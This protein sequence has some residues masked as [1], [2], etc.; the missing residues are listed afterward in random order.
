MASTTLDDIIT[1]L[2]LTYDSSVGVLEGDHI[3]SVPKISV[4]LNL[5]KLLSKLDRQL[6]EVEQV[7]KSVLKKIKK[8]A[9]DGE[10]DED[11]G[12]GDKKRF[13]SLDQ[14]EEERPELEQRK[15]KIDGVDN[16]EDANS[17]EED[18]AAEVEEEE[19]DDDEGPE[20]DAV[21][22]TIGGADKA[23]GGAGYDKDADDDVPL[24]NKRKP[25]VT[26]DEDDVGLAKRRKLVKSEADGE[27]YGKE[28]D[29]KF[30][31]ANAHGEAHEDDND[32]QEDD[33]DDN[34]DEHEDGINT[35]KN[36]PPE[37]RGHYT[38]END[39]RLKNP[40]SEF[41]TSQ[42]LPAEAIAKLGLF[43]ESNNGLETHGK[44]YLKKKYG[45]ASYPENDLYDLLPGPIPNTDFSKNKPPSNQVQFTTF[46]SYIESFFRPFVP[47]DIDFLKEKY[48]IPAIGGFDEKLNNYDPATT[49]FLIPKLGP[50]YADLWTAADLSLANKISSPSPYQQGPDSYLPKG[51]ID[52]LSDDKLYTEDISCGPLSSRLL[53]AILCN[54]ESGELAGDDIK[55]EDNFNNDDELTSS[56]VPQPTDI[57]VA[58]QLD[59]NNE[60]YKLTSEK[61]DF[62]S[63]EERL[64]R[65]LKYIG[66]FMNLPNGK[67]K[68]VN[69]S[70]D[71]NAASNSI[72]GD[73]SADGNDGTGSGTGTGDIN[74]GGGSEGPGGNGEGSGDGSHIIDNDEWI[75]NREDDEVCAELRALQRELQETYKRNRQNKK[76]LIP[77]VDDQLAFQEYCTILEDLDKQVDQAYIKRLRVKNKKKKGHAHSSSN[78]ASTPGA[79]GAGSSESAAGLQQTV[80]SGLRS[81][82]DKRSKWIN[83]IGKLFKSPELMKRAPVE[84]VLSGAIESDDEADDEDHIDTAAETIMNKGH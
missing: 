39:T 29:I 77:I 11:G 6:Q 12:E 55:T 9:G 48:V 40:K 57:D 74:N 36:L 49:P 22:R 42:T 7:D 76:K 3:Q 50:F 81:L 20:D 41:V 15:D 38:H 71:D 79:T 44:E 25:S 24:H 80:N 54:N 8:I 70:N 37:Q 17:N 84:S 61:S 31:D 26:D 4:L 13:G 46:Q 75:K 62:H 53:S 2:R 52:N 73:T 60:S 82:L 59:L 72:N 67:K 58:T 33:E 27:A 10:D 18:D 32:L 43:S 69:D 51:S 64:K 56:P 30:E 5:S 68:N 14:D 34:G 1:E 47:E 63:I 66:I 83:N 65:E 35:D 78:A 16:G 23:N 45:V 21:D 19:E 28:R